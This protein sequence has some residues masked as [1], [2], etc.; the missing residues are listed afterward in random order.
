MFTMTV[1]SFLIFVSTLYYLISTSTDLDSMDQRRFRYFFLATVNARPSA[2]TSLRCC[3][4]MF[5]LIHFTS[6]SARWR[7]YIDTMWLHSAQLRC[8]SLYWRATVY[9]EVNWLPNSPA[10]PFVAPPPKTYWNWFF[11]W[12]MWQTSLDVKS[13]TR[14]RFRKKC[15]YDSH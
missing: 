10:P 6:V 12:Q 7:L 3:S 5:G 8:R 4:T 14:G 2:P 11:Y 9:K 1:Y 15:R 13:T